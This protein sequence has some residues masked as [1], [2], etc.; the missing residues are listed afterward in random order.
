MSSEALNALLSD[1]KHGGAFALQIAEDPSLATGYDLSAEEREA[2]IGRDLETLRRLGASD[3]LLD[4]VEMIG[5]PRGSP[6]G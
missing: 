2:L 3:H 4:A 6:A 1:V 5:R